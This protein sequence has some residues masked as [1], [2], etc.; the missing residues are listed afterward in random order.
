MK[1]QK[2][3]P[4]FRQSL[5]GVPY[6]DTP[7]GEPPVR[8]KTATL[9]QR[10]ESD[11]VSTTPAPT[12]VSAKQKLQKDLDPTQITSSIGESSGSANTEVY[13]ISSQT[14]A[15]SIPK[16]RV[17]NPSKLNGT[18]GGRLGSSKPPRSKDG[19][20]PLSTKLPELSLNLPNG[21]FSD[22]IKVDGMSFTKR[23][24]MLIEG[25]KVSASSTQSRTPRLSG[26]ASRKILSEEEESLS[27][28]VRSFYDTGT[29]SL[30]HVDVNSIDQ[31][32]RSRWLSS[33]NTA[34][35]LSTP[36]ASRTT[37]ATD[38][39]SQP[40]MPSIRINE[41][42]SRLSMIVREENELAGGIEDWQDV[43]DGDV[44]RYGFILTRPPQPGSPRQ[45]SSANGPLP[46]AASGLHTVAPS[47]LA[48]S[49]GPRRKGTIRRS[50]G[51]NNVHRHS[52]SGARTNR[53]GDGQAE[54][55]QRPSTASVVRRQS[56]IR[57]ATNR[58][59]QNRN[60]RLRD[61]ASDI[62]T[63]APAS[64][65]GPA[66]EDVELGSRKK[67]K[68]TERE[69]KWRKMARLVSSKSGGGMVFDFDT[70]DPKL[71]DRTWKGI[72]DRWRASAWYAFL[73]TSAKRSHT[74]PAEDDLITMFEKYN[75][76]SSPDDVQIDIDVPRTISN[77]IMFRRRYRGG[78]RLLFRVLHA[79]SLHFPDT[80]YVQGMATLAATLLAY[81]DEQRAFVMLVRLWDL[82][83]LGRLYQEGFG[84]LMQALGDF[85]KGW[86]GEGEVAKKLVCQ[87]ALQQTCQC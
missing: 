54:E 17:E 24:S 70:K 51:N 40:S 46:R 14:S 76:I 78:Q 59:P 66:E 65:R 34:E 69:E 86:L 52:I 16:I 31:E 77:H 7:P 61:Q 87:S 47:L 5:H 44:D 45:A 11:D 84:G 33:V 81:F 27:E 75:E 4:E 41:R 10:V 22:D 12:Y 74:S 36:S 48:A 8:V 13:S 71:I 19:R 21:A 15:P 85:E 26:T 55:E 28:R 43:K 62:F 60:R 83:G 67:R 73:A 72:P 9:P 68:E 3:I 42:P 49:D 32:M 63:P 39:R 64:R 35:T 56:I 23:G 38:L 57:Q 2:S 79:M 18:E 20:S 50:V 53:S 58:L 29:E 82:R 37:S 30:S 6:D 25:R 1:S 80:G